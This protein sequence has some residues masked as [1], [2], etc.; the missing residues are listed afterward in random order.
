MRIRTTVVSLVLG[1]LMAA[2]PALA[3][4]KTIADAAAMRQAVAAQVQA[5]QQTRAAVQRVLARDQVQDVAATLGLDVVTAE[6]AL[7]TLSSAELA[8]LAGPAQQVD[9]ALAGGQST[10]VISTTTLLLIIIIVILLAR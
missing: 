10:I 4:Q 1:V 6:R 8:Q 7:A 3:Q 9:A 5:D 2:T